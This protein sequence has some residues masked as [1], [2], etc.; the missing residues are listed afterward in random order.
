MMVGQDHCE[1]VD[2]NWETE[3]ELDPCY[4]P[5]ASRCEY[6]PYWNCS[7]IILDI[8]RNGFRLTGLDEPVLFD[9]DADGVLDTIAWTAADEEDGLL[10]LDRN[11]DGRISDGGE[12]FGDSTQLADGSEAP[13]GFAAL[14]EFDLTWAGGDGSGVIDAG[15]AVF[16]RLRVWFDRDHDGVSE[17][18]ELLTLHELGI[19]RIDLEFVE[20]GGRRDRHGNRLRYNGKAWMALPSRQGEAPIACSDVYF[21]VAP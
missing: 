9:I 21:Q 6:D 2:D 13:H 20:S 7:P 4:D 18:G 11:G 15:D 17:P 1:Q 8:D 16:T 5:N 12:L 10:A 14:A 3:T 19:V